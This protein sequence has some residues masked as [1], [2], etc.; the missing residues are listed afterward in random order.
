MYFYAIFTKIKET[1]N[2]KLN[3]EMEV[4][5]V[6]RKT[7]HPPADLPE[8]IGMFTLAR[9]HGA[10]SRMQWECE[11]YYH[12]CLYRFVVGPSLPLNENL[13]YFFQPRKELF[14]APVRNF[15]IVSVFIMRDLAIPAENGLYTLSFIPGFNETVII[16]SDDLGVKF[17]VAPKSPNQ[18]NAKHTVWECSIGNVRDYDH[19]KMVAIVE[20]D[21]IKE[22]EGII[23][24][25][26][27]RLSSKSR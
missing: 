17:V 5:V 20:V 21:L 12:G 9:K 22:K 10:A 8:M 25:C 4:T 2:L 24:V 15:R 1:A 19:E 7:E 16:P 27:C 11:Q 26:L 13:H 18:P 3:M 23:D 14:T 6:S